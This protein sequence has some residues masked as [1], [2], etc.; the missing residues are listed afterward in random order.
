MHWLDIGPQGISF[1]V[2]LTGGDLALGVLD[3]TSITSTTS[4][5]RARSLRMQV[6]LVSSGESRL[7]GLGKAHMT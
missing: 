5:Q 4:L 2:H 7:P 1:A 3:Y 6:Q